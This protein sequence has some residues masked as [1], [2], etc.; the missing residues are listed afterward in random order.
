MPRIEYNIVDEWASVSDLIMERTLIKR[1]AEIINMDYHWRQKRL[2]IHLIIH[3]FSSNGEGGY[4]RIMTETIPSYGHKLV[5]DNDTICNAQT[6][7]P[8][9][10]TK[11]EQRELQEIVKEM[12]D[13]EEIERQGRLYNGVPYMYQW[14]YFKMLARTQLI[15]VDPMIYQFIQGL[16]LSDVKVPF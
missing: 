6:G 12:K 3:H 10:E 13:G 8:I 4:G 14:D 7:L 16:D 1:K 5:A 9:C 11:D 2:I 15:P